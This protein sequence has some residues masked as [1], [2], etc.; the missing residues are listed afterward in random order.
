MGGNSGGVRDKYMMKMLEKAFPKCGTARLCRCGRTSESHVPIRR[1]QSSCQKKP[2]TDKKGLDKNSTGLNCR[3]SS[4]SEETNF[5]KLMSGSDDI[6]APDTKVL[7][8]KIE[9]TAVAST[10]EPERPP[11]QRRKLPFSEE[12]SKAP[13]KESGGER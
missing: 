7:E 13:P 5:E 3:W 1:L 8:A 6:S 4:A 11:S 2:V 9:E 10:E 12:G